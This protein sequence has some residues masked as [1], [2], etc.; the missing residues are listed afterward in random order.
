MRRTEDLTKDHMAARLNVCLCYS[1]T[2]E[3]LTA[4]DKTVELAA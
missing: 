3:I 4:M 1:S 2:E